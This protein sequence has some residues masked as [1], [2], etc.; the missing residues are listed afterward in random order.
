VSEFP[1][2]VL[3][4][5]VSRRQDFARKLGGTIPRSLGEAAWQGYAEDG[6][7]S[8]SCSCLHERGGFG[9]SELSYYLARAVQAGRV[10]IRI[11]KPHPMSERPSE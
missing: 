11:V 4:V 9:L 2:E 3:P 1:N 8:Q 6:H 7:G 5:Q 10:E